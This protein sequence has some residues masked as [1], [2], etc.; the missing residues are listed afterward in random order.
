MWQMSSCFRQVST[1]C[2]EVTP[3]QESIQVPK[4]GPGASLADTHISP[5]CLAQMALRHSVISSA[6][7]ADAPSDRCAP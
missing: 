7:P 3:W 4:E 2:D 1:C 6:S 5:R